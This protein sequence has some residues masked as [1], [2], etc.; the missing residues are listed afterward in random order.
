VTRPCP[1]CGARGLARDWEGVVCL[2]CAWREGPELDLPLV[3]SGPVAS[4]SVWRESRM[5]TPFG[6]LLR[7]RGWTQARL[8]ARLRVHTKTIRAWGVGTHRPRPERIAEIARILGVDEAEV[9]E[10]LRWR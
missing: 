9:R 7:A 10:A 5:Q 1:R 2:L 4:A 6:Q 8:A 3:H